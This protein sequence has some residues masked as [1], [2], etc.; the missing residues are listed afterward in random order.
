MSY[1]TEEDFVHPKKLSHDYKM[2]ST[3]YNWFYNCA[4]FDKE[5]TTPKRK[6]IKKRNNFIRRQKKLC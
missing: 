4:K 5:R 6:D 1:F 2:S 3:K